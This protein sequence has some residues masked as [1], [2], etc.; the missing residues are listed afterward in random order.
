MT[1]ISSGKWIKYVSV[2]ISIAAIAISIRSCSLSKQSN[3]IA[4][5][6]LNHTKKAFISE[7]RPYLILQPV[8]DKEKGF[9]IDLSLTEKDTILTS[10]FEIYNAGNT[11]AQ[12]VSTKGLRVIAKNISLSD[13]LMTNL[14][15]LPVIS[16]GPGEKR[17]IKFHSRIGFKSGNDENVKK[18]TTGVVIA[19]SIKFRITL[20]LSYSSHMDD[21]KQFRT[22]VTY[23]FPNFREAYLL[24][25]IYE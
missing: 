9:F 12:S 3:Q 2:G 1:K 18:N 8:K 20:P 5:N 7:N 6:A 22:T 15:A 23:E 11:P 14:K 21:T 24:E 4:E 16:L 25:S 13:D 19:E 10:T 17:F